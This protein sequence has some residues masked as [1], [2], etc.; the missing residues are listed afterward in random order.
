MSLTRCLAYYHKV[1]GFISLHRDK[2]R[3]K[4][5]KRSEISGFS[6]SRDVF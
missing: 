2:E 4:R 6:L 3:K 5:L 1:D